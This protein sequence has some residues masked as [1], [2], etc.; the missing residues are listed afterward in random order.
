MPVG[1]QFAGV[2]QLPLVLA[3]AHET[4]HPLARDSAANANRAAAIAS[5][6]TIATRH[7]IRIGADTISGAPRV[8]HCKEEM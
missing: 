6:S 8:R 4:S 1:D 3:D 2:F 7:R 5:A